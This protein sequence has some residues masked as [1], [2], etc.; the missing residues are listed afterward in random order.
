MPEPIVQQTRRGSYANHADQ[1][2]E[3]VA[4]PEMKRC[5]SCDDRWIVANQ[6]ECVICALVRRDGV[7]A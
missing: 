7:A 4:A 3:A 5:P 1:F 2:P 6:R